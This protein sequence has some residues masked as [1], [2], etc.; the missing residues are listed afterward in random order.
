MAEK[1]DDISIEYRDPASNQVLVQQF[2]AIPLTR[3]AWTTIMFKYRE[4]TSVEAD[5]GP[6]K[7]RVG[8]YRKRN[9]QFQQQSK[10]N[11]SSVDQA[12]ALV[13]ILN[14]WIEEDQDADKS[15]PA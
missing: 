14:T 13:E 12:K 10:F 1:I 7:Y 4:R 15:S 2:A 9:G 6:I 11:I 3:G 5:F 8:R